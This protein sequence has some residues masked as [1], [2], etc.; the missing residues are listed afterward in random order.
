MQQKWT[1]KK[2]FISIHYNLYKGPVSAGPFCIAKGKAFEIH[3][4]TLN[5]VA[6]KLYFDF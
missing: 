5:S 3:L 1:L 2:C 6:H 4:K